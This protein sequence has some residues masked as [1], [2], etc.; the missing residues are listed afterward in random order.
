MAKLDGARSKV[1]RAK[2][3]FRTLVVKHQEFHGLNQFGQ[4]VRET[5]VPHVQAF[6]QGSA[7]GGGCVRQRSK[8]ALGFDPS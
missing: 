7:L 2:E 8:A 1:Q 4:H 6:D 5:R 3:H